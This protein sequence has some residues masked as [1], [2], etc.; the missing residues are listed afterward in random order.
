MESEKI[1]DLEKKDYREILVQDI[2][3]LVS[4]R[5]AT[6]YKGANISDAVKAII[7]AKTQKCYVIDRKGILLGTITIETLLRHAGYRVGAREPGVI[8][9]FRFIREILKDRVDDIMAQPVPV[10]KEDKLVDALKLMAEYHLNDLPVIDDSG[11][12]IGEL[13]ALEVLILAK[14]WFHQKK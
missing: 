10:K 12:L 13:N 1:S 5:P 2:Y 3:R 6:V 7:E 11:R 9:F 4:S 14:K 8:P